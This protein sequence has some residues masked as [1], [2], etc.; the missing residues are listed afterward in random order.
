MVLSLVV[1]LIGIILVFV[2]I[3]YFCNTEYRGAKVKENDNGDLVCKNYTSFILKCFLISL[4]WPFLLFIFLA[5]YIS[6]NFEKSNM[7]HI[8]KGRKKRKE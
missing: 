2:S 7:N 1:Y 6:H 4:L 5:E 3:Y 8:A